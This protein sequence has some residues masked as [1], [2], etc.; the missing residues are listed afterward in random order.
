[1]AAIAICVPGLDLEVEP[2]SARAP[3]KSSEFTTD[4][5]LFDGLARAQRGQMQAAFRAA[6]AASLRYRQVFP[7][8]L[9]GN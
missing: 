1:L 9:G 8:R 7:P 3:A 4:A 2:A 5:S 6:R